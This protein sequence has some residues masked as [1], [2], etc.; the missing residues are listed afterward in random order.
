MRLNHYQQEA[1]RTL[2]GSIADAVSGL[3]DY[4]R[5]SLGGGS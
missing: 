5:P 2:R 1:S 4:A 3:L